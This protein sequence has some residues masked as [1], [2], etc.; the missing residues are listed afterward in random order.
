MCTRKTREREQ[1]TREHKLV[2]WEHEQV[3]R[4]HEQTTWE[5]CH[6]CYAH[7]VAFCTRAYVKFKSSSTVCNKQ[8]N[9]V[10]SARL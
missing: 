3:T 6:E 4:E 8:Q 7:A 5:H 1:A 9:C 2:T 10:L